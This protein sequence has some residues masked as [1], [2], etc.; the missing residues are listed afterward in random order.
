MADLQAGEGKLEM[1]IQITR[2]ETGEVEE[3]QLTSEPDQHTIET[4]E[5]E[6]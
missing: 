3:Y 6:S 5:E 4:T 1:T 2:A